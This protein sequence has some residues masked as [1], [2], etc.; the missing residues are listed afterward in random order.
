MRKLY[1]TLGLIGL[2]IPILGVLG[3]YSVSGGLRTVVADTLGQIQVV[4][5][6]RENV[7][8]P[9][10][11]D[12]PADMAERLRRIP[13]VRAVDSRVSPETYA[14]ST[15]CSVQSPSRERATSAAVEKTCSSSRVCTLSL[16]YRSNK[17]VVYQ[18]AS[19][20]PRSVAPNVGVGM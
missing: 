2:A 18:S 11:S 16:T 17:A 4:V 3:L 1:A 8:M 19:S 13:G 7:P 20:I 14:I 6:V 10:F 12:L 5:V 15:A 9:V